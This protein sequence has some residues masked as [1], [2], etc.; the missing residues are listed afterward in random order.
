MRPPFKV[1]ACFRGAHL[2][3]DREEPRP[4]IVAHTPQSTCSIPVQTIFFCNF[5]P[6]TFEL[7]NW[8]IVPV[9]A[10]SWDSGQS[11]FNTN[12]AILNGGV[13]KGTDG[14]IIWKGLGFSQNGPYDCAFT[15]ATNGTVASGYY[16]FLDQLNETTPGGETGPW[17]LYYKREPTVD[18]CN[19]VYRTAPNFCGPKAC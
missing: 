9:L 7:H 8:H 2:G 13:Y 14:S 10:K 16:T 19:S 18:E 6:Y 1:H 5:K 17:I 4:H 12:G 11:S 3:P 15:L